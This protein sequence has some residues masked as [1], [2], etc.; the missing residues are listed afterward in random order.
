MK[1]VITGGAGFLG[2]HLARKLSPCFDEIRIL[3]IA[4]VDV[5]EYPPN[6]IPVRADV[7]D[8]SSLERAFEGASCVVH[9]AA[10]LPLWPRNDIDSTNVRG[11]E[12]VL[13]AAAKEGVKRVVHV[14][15][16]AVYG[17]PKKHPIEEEDPLVGVGPYGKSKILA[18]KICLKFR[19]KGLCVPII[20]PKTFI[21]TARLGV[22][23]I[24][25]D[26]VRSGCKIP[27]IGRG[28]NRYQLLDVEDLTEGIALLMRAPR[29]KADR[30][31]NIGAQKF[32]TVEEDLESLC[33]FAGT[34]ARVMSTP[35]GMVKGILALLSG[36]RLSPLYPW[37]YATADK[38]SFVSTLRIQQELGWSA[39]YSNAEALRRSYQWYLEHAGELS[40]TGVTHRAPWKQG[41]LGLIKGLLT[42][43]RS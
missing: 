15:S 33:S 34:G 11:T 17:I 24:L 2:F 31:F 43:R 7:R 10:A 25:F 40:E 26:W 21:G 12:N 38:D 13:A 16:T 20:R 6:A 29:E 30:T 42:P 28:N 39:G 22:F 37:I 9:A 3:D 36:L 41:V 8:V 27:V 18:E 5:R 4:P 32:G 19:G 35:A 14:S 23:Q 1:L